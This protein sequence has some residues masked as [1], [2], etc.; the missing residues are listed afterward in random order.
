MTISHDEAEEALAAIRAVEHRTRASIVGS[1]GYVYLIVTGIVWLLGFAA[2][3]FLEGPLLSAIWGTLSVVGSLAGILLGSRLGRRV[4]APAMVATA[5]RA[6]LIWGLLVLYGAAAIAV[7][8]PTDGRQ[9]TMLIILFSMVGQLAMGLLLGF[10][11]VWWAVP[12]T[13]LALAGY[14][15]APGIFYLW[16]AVLGGGGM[17]AL[18]LIIRSRW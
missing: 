12:V 4:R 17:V 7:A 16:M 14:T 8:H 1:H 5:K 15:F 3:Q 2:T 11:S 13:L 10:A 9:V 18:G 6:I